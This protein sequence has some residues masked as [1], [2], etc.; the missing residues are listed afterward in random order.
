LAYVFGEHKRFIG[1]I[2]INKKQEVNV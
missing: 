1:Q 2:H